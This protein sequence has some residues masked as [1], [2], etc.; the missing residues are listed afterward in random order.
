MSA[1]A[2]TTTSHSPQASELPKF[3]WKL[4]DKRW[5]KLT[6][7]L[8]LWPGLCVRPVLYESSHSLPNSNKYLLS[9]PFPRRNPTQRLPMTFLR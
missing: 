9:F 1:L 4:S 6:D 8:F 5:T 7:G 2:N 3:K